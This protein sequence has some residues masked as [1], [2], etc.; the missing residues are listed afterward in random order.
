MSAWDR[1]EE[2]ISSSS[3]S[4][5]EI[6]Q[7]IDP[8]SAAD[9]LFAHIFFETYLELYEGHRSEEEIIA[10]GKEVAQSGRVAT[11]K[12]DWRKL[13]EHCDKLFRDKSLPDI[14]TRTY[15]FRVPILR[16]LSGVLLSN[17]SLINFLAPLPVQAEQPKP[18]PFELDPI[19]WEFF[20]QLA[21]SYLDPLNE[22][23]IT[24]RESLLTDR[25]AEIEALQRRCLSLAEE[26]KGETNIDRLQRNIAQHIRIHVEAEMQQLFSLNK[27]AVRDLFNKVMADEKFWAGTATYIYSIFNGGAV[28]SAASGIYALS[29]VGSKAMQALAGRSEKLRTSDFALLYRMK[30]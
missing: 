11:K 2:L 29:N 14:L 16:Q 8:Y 9:E 21:S 23:A 30:N 24:K 19:A 18:N 1:S 5:E 17:Q 27:D 15:M 20:R 3:L 12:V 13:Y 22:T 10:L 6:N 25:T 7:L 4:G 28:L 26:F